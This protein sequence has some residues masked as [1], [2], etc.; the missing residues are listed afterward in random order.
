MNPGT[1]NNFCSLLSVC[2][3]SGRPILKK[4]F[5]VTACAML[6]AVLVPFETVPAAGTPGG[7]AAGLGGITVRSDRFPLG[8]VTLKN[9]EYRGPAAPGSISAMTVKLTERQTFGTVH[10]RDAAAVV[11]VTDPGG[12]GTFFDLVL[13]FKKND[14]WVNVDTVFLGDRVKVYSI[15]IKDNEIL[16]GMITH[17]PKDALCCPTWEITRRYAIQA[18][19]LIAREG[20][21]KAAIGMNDIVGPVW[22]WVGTRYPDDT[23]Q[24]PAANTS[25]YTLQLGQDGTIHVRG[26]CN[27]SGGSFTL[28]NPDLAITIT[29]STRAA[30][31][32]G[33][34]E[35]MFIRDLNRT[36]RLLLKNG[37]LFLGLKLDS[38]T[39]EFQKGPTHDQ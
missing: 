5:V 29:H 30:C 27:V 24:R 33:S 18:D 17:G 31:P 6:L 15:D 20:A 10:G 1:N 32:E 9:G 35:D 19:R 8:A 13:L 2:F 38:G 34:L 11:I 36:G 3:T 23:S 25:G 22:H 7:N 16:L 4:Q 37:R 21:T 12:S 26:D 28:K 14:G 39:M